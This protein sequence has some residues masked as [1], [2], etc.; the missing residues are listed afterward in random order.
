M[1][2]STAGWTIAASVAITG[3]SSVRADDDAAVRVVSD[4]MVI[5]PVGAGGEAPARA[6]VTIAN[7][8]NERTAGLLI[9]ALPSASECLKLVGGAARAPPGHIQISAAS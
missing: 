4:V 2:V 9:I 1:D 5:A 8:A 7:M 6:P 3:A